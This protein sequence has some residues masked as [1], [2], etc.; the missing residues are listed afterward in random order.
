VWLYA[1]K[2]CSEEF[3]FESFGNS[4]IDTELQKLAYRLNIRKFLEFG[5]NNNEDR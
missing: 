2:N 1:R 3:L 5:A 4:N